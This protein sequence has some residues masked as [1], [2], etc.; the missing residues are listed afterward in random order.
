[1]AALASTLSFG[2]VRDGTPAYAMISAIAAISLRR[3]P[4]V[5]HA[6]AVAMAGRTKYYEFGRTV[7]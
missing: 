7:C 2:Q 3:R 6:M 5:S 1:M 4:T